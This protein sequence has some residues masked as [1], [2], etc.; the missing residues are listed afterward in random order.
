MEEI[1]SLFLDLL[2]FGHTVRKEQLIIM[3][4]LLYDKSF[5]VDYSSI[6]LNGNVLFTEKSVINFFSAKKQLENGEDITDI[7]LFIDLYRALL[8]KNECYEL[9][10]Y[11]KL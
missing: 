7:D 11:L 6:E 9:L 1:K 10:S 5:D 4:S 2:L 8:I 3:L